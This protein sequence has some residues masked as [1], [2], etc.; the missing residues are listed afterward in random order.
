MSICQSCAM[1]LERDED[2][3]TNADGSKNQEYCCHCFK[4]G[5]FIDSDIS[6]DR[7]IEKVSEIMKGM[8]M[9]DDVIIQTQAMIP[10]LKRWR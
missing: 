3:A 1:P 4:E 6:M 7:F 2:L 5:V 10:T 8:Q 9:P